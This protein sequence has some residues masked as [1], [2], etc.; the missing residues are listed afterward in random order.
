M[1]E[2]R[3]LSYF[4]KSTILSFA[5]LMNI[6]LGYS[7]FLG[8]QSFFAWRSLHTKYTELTAEL[9]FINQKKASLSQQIRLLQNDSAYIE[10]I[11]RQRLNYVRENEILYIFEKETEEPSPWLDKEESLVN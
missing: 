5:I 11:I 8:D 4:W 6:T 1:K 3:T 7:L 2:K 10:K 9:D